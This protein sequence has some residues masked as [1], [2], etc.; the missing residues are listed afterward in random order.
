MNSTRIEVLMKSDY[1]TW[2]MQ[3]EAL[4]VKHDE[5]IYASGIRKRPVSKAG[6]LVPTEA[7]T[8]WDQC[9]LKAKVYI[10]L[11]I[12]PAV[13]QHVKGCKTAKDVW[14]KLQSVY[15]SRG[16]VRKA[17]LQQLTLQ[18]LH[19]GDDVREHLMKFFDAVDKLESMDI[20]INEDMLV[21]LLLYSLPASYEGFRCAME[22]RDELPSPEILILAESESREQR[23]K[24]EEI[25]GAL[26]AR[27]SKKHFKRAETKEENSDEKKFK[28][29]CYK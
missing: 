8:T 4:L 20:S 19:E 11:M 24:R 25:S 28:F 14:Q 17:A 13:L 15:A 21:I 16:P 23:N 1:D 9:D 6:E 22:C 27:Q 5:W 7:Q 3:A 26:L 10:I 29:K 2:L 18:K 12:S